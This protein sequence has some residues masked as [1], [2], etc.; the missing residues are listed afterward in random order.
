MTEQAAPVNALAPN[1]SDQAEMPEL[2]ALP[3]KTPTNWKP[4]ALGLAIG[5]IVG[6]GIGAG[7]TLATTAPPAAPD[8]EQ[9]FTDAIDACNAKE[10]MDI[11]D[12]GTTL[13]IDTKG[14][15]D[16]RGASISDLACVLGELNI[17][18]SALNNV[19]SIRALD[20]RQTE[21]WGEFSFTYS[22]HPDSG[23]SGVVT[24]AQ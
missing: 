17:T 8:T 11:G 1:V 19:S 23:L 24:A 3:A 13:V 21:T 5:L 20:G 7:I 4:L 18:D 6:G 15:D 9:V 22:Y 14:T 12:G 16:R 2:P 10:G